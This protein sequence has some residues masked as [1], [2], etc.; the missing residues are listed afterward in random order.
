M[1]NGLPKLH[2]EMV[3]EISRLTN[4]INFIYNL[5]SELSK[6]DITMCECSKGNTTVDCCEISETLTKAHGLG[7]S[8]ENQPIDIAM[9][10]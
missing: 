10:G 7:N 1:Q 2:E 8:P 3:I 5:F 4:C 9:S 6:S